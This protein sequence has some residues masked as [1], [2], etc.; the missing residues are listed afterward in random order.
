MF[1]EWRGVILDLDGTILE[2]AVD[3]AAVDEQVSAKFREL[4]YSVP[5]EDAWEMLAYADEREDRAPI[6]DIISTAEIH[7]AEDSS[8]L[9]LADS[10][11][12]IE[13]PVAVCTLN[14]EKAARVALESHELDQHIETVVGRDTVAAWKPDPL[15]LITAV[16]RISRRPQ[17]SVFVGDSQRD[18]ITADR[19]GVDFRYVETVLEGPQ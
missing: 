15:P 2:L 14:C 9:P 4:G 7:G 8:A 3:W 18:A 6:E 19:A 16:E 10:L 17:D 5:A 13:R 11:P 12:E 1:D